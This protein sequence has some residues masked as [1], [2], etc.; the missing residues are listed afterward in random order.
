MAAGRCL[1]RR[2]DEPLQHDVRPVF[3]HATLNQV[4]FVHELSWD[5]IKMV[6]INAIS[7]KP[8]RQMLGS[9]LGRRADAFAVFP[10]RSA[11]CAESRLQ[12]C[13]GGDQRH[14]VRQAP[15]NSRSRRPR[16]EEIL[17]AHL[18]LHR[19]RQRGKLASPRRQPVRR[20][21]AR[22]RE[23]ALARASTSSRSSRS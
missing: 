5:D 7:I 18:Q 15:W 9:V 23:P 11:I 14:R 4:G 3:L 13:A 8:R 2:P 20:E 6:L 22:D 21:A 17:Y 16:R 1:T 12:Q 10:R 19:H